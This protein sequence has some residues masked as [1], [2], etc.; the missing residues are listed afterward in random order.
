M[1]TLLHPLCLEA[2]KLDAA[3]AHDDA[4]N[5]LATATQAGDIEAKTRLAK[6][7]ISGINAPYLPNDGASLL[8]EAAGQ[9]GPEALSLCASLTALGVLFPRDW[10]KAIE[11]LGYAAMFGWE[12]AR[13]QLRVMATA[14]P[15]HPLK[16]PAADNSQG[17]LT[18]AREIDLSFWFTLPPGEILNEDPRISC[19]RQL[20]PI[21][22]CEH[23][24]VRSRSRLTRARVYD[25]QHGKDTYSETRSNSIA[26]FTLL[27][28]DL[29]HSLLQERM[30]LAAQVPPTHMEANAILHYSPGQGIA[31]HFDFVSPDLPDYAGEI[32][33][34][35]QRAFTFL[36]ALNDSYSA[37]E[38]GFPKLQLQWRGNPG[39][40][41]LFCNIL[42][43]NSPDLRTLH[44]GRPPTS[45]EKWIVSQFIRNRPVDRL[46]GQV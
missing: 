28:C 25:A 35:G 43:D 15:R 12:G 13:Q 30:A 2:E 11:G 38:T 37:G 40:G 5:A 44:A 32:A 20:L 23:L 16:I 29:I 41:L 7:L 14:D 34:N 31:N 39:D 4:I 9:G 10:N 6:R 26:E 45:G 27:E 3:N 46:T 22:A 42:P 8:G 36:V 24:I 33:R 17:W 1:T 21:S 18:L 19:F